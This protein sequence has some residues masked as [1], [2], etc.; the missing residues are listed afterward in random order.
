MFSFLRAFFHPAHTE[1]NAKLGDEETAPLLD[2]A[3]RENEDS[4]RDPPPR[5]YG[6][7]DAITADVPGNGHVNSTDKSNSKKADDQRQEGK[8]KEERK[9]WWTYL[10]QFSI[11]I[12][13]IWP[14]R[15]LRL[16]L[17]L[18]GVVLCLL[19]IRFLN[20]LAPRQL[21][22]TI[23]SLGKSRGRLPVSELLLYLFFDSL[24]AS[25]IVSSIQGYLWLSVQQNA[26]KA[27]VTTTFDHIMGLSCTF[28]DNKKSGELYKS[29][30]QG[31]A[32]LSL[33]DSAFFNT[34]PMLV[35]LGV[36]CVYL[37][38]LFG[39]YMALLV[40]TIIITYLSTLKYL[41][42]MQVD[43]KRQNT[44]ASRKEYQVMY[45]ALGN[46]ISVAYF[47]NFKY[48]NGRY[49]AAV[50]VTLKTWLKYTILYYL[51]YIIQSSMLQLGFVAAA[52]LAAYQIS[53]GKITVGDFVLLVDYWARLSS[54]IYD[55]E[56]YS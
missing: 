19:A 56:R 15:N 55:S 38:H 25:G 31:S 44:E 37:S 43:I 47:G 2:D 29:M 13:F 23:N 42:A 9:H 1:G 21:G 24:T 11:F 22:I 3:A 17:H 27:I 36:A 51:S 32:V 4:P 28:H 5:R 10:R 12:P 53:T 49:K 39:R 34:L 8:P 18:A 26:H 48:E 46:W 16:Q 54:R 33:F 52:F 50:E 35:D 7:T 41:A 45:D 40:A 14:S 30:G 20:V 6:S